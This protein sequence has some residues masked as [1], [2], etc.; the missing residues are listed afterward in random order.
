MFVA[1]TPSKL[2]VTAVFTLRQN[3]NHRIRECQTHNCI[4]PQ[5]TA[6]VAFNAFAVTAHALRLPL[7]PDSATKAIPWPRMC[8]TVRG[9]APQPPT[10]QCNPQPTLVVCTSTLSATPHT[11]TISIQLHTTKLQPARQYV[12]IGLQYAL[13]RRVGSHAHAAPVTI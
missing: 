4:C 11:T 8:T 1:Y 10:Y 6:T 9:T 7:Y 3:I 13:Y 5:H 2:F 12:G